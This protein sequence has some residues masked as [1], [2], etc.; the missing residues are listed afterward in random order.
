MCNGTTR[1]FVALYMCY[2]VVW[3]TLFITDPRKLSCNHSVAATEGGMGHLL[4]ED[5]RGG[6]SSLHGTL[7]H[8]EI[9]LLT[10]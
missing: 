10:S 5:G 6:H 9:V 1:V 2:G 8:I 7:N 3:P 4:P